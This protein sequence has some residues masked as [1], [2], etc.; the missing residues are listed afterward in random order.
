MRCKEKDVLR[1]IHAGTKIIPELS[2]FWYQNYSCFWVQLSD[3]YLPL[4]LPTGE[5]RKCIRSAKSYPPLKF[6][7]H[8]LPP[9]F[10]TFLRNPNPIFHTIPTHIFHTIPTHI[11]H[12]IPTPIF[13]R[14]RT[15][16]RMII[17]HP[18]NGSSKG[19]STLKLAA[20]PPE[21]LMKTQ[22]VQRRR[23]NISREN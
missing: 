22:F 3:Y 20:R 10:I 17:K 21:K 1:Q 13:S 19:I 9:F 16:C 12:T 18:Q 6:R 11:F 5:G 14:I 23:S 8:F 7:F 2:P 4:F 15:I